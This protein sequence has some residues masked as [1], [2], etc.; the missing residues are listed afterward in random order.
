[1]VGY[2]TAASQL[3]FPRLPL[4]LYDNKVNGIFLRSVIAIIVILRFMLCFAV[5]RLTRL[6]LPFTVEKQ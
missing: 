6:F 2:T 1:M 4:N 3:G 5:Y